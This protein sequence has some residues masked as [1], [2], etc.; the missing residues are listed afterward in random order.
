MKAEAT[1]L[2][3]QSARHRW[4]ELLMMQRYILSV[5]KLQPVFQVGA[6]PRYASVFKSLAIMIGFATLD[7]I[8]HTRHASD[9][10]KAD[11][12]EWCVTYVNY[13]FTPLNSKRE[14]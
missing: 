10:H 4:G 14:G 1:Y 8:C 2:A 6:P 11:M 12:Y 9:P 7:W 3:K 5:A 13:G